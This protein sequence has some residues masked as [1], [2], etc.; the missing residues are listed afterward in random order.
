MTRAP[1]SWVE[2]HGRQVLVAFRAVALWSHQVKRLIRPIAG[3]VACRQPLRF[4][5]PLGQVRGAGPARVAASLT[6]LPAVGPV[7]QQCANGRWSS[8]E[9]QD[10]ERNRLSEELS[11]VPIARFDE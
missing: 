11:K 7:E 8:P 3:L 1:G 6:A 2:T 4:H 10:S 5:G 9:H